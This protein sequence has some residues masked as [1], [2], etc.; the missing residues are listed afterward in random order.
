VKKLSIL[1]VCTANICRS[2]MAEGLLLLHAERDGL[3]KALVVQSAG[4]HVRLGGQRP[5][6]R[7]QRAA[8][9]VGVDLGRMRSRQ[10]HAR[11]FARQD[12]ILGMDANNRRYL[13]EA[14]PAQYAH[15][16]ALIL[17]FAPETGVADVPDPYFGS[18][19]G[20][21]RV[22]ELLEAGVAGLLRHVRKEQ[23]F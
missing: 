11:D 3:G 21:E 19:A 14:C 1:M 10:V 20:F 17:D 5:D 6:A 18:Y 2:P 4:T 9:S 13:L 16:V 23:K 22:L 8:A 15:K 12:Y 7:A